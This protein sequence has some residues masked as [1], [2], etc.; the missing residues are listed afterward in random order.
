MEGCKISNR[1][2]V[3]PLTVYTSREWS[4]EKIFC[5]K[6]R[7]FYLYKPLFS[8]TCVIFD[9]CDHQFFPVILTVMNII[10]LP[11]TSV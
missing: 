1:P 11:K 5:R 2:Y 4:D 3:R 9:C 10:S 7:N 8:D 6:M